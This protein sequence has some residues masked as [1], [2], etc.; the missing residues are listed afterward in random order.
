MKLPRCFLRTTIPSLALLLLTTAGASADTIILKNGTRYQGRV[1]K[2]EGAS[3]LLEIQVTRSIRD[4]RRVAKADIEKIEKEDAAGAQWAEMAKLGA[5]PDLMEASDY[6]GRI[7]RIKGFIDQFTTA[8]QTTDARRLIK[9]LEAERDSITAGAIK[10]GGH[11]ISPTER[12]ADMVAID[13]AILAKKFEKSAT[14]GRVL[15]SLRL[16]DS[17]SAQ[18]AGSAA[19][20][21]A[22]P[23]ANRV[24]AADAAQINRSLATLDE[25][26]KQ[27]EVGLERM[28]AVDRERAKRIFAQQQ[29]AFDRQVAIEKDERVK[30]VTVNP[31][32]KS[33]LE[34]AKR[35]IDSEIKRLE[36]PSTAKNTAPDEGYREAWKALDGADKEEARKIMSDVG[37][38]N[39]PKIYEQKLEE[40]AAA[41]ATEEVPGAETE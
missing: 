34:D 27:R 29:A 11:I 7:R 1:L 33:S 15:E 28:P 35:R 5:T 37:R 17:I 32:D 24:L 23:L 16:F 22:L 19:H 6:D 20:V 40:R 36:N 12:D 2:D 25:R 41:A 26:L 3:Y 8:K 4:E 38:L 10:L 9:T 18:F 39:L 14:G 30:W 31:F 21:K 13:S